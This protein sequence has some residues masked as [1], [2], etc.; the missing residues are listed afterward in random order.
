MIQKFIL[1]S[2]IILLYLAIVRCGVALTPKATVKLPPSTKTEILRLNLLYGDSDDIY[3]L[4]LGI[5]NVVQ[6]HL[7]GIQ[8]GVVNGAERATGIQIGAVNNA[9]ATWSLLK[10][11]LFNLNFFLDSGRRQPRDTPESI[12]RRIKGDAGFS[13]G[14]VN[15]ASGRYNVGLFN[16]G[17]GWNV[18][19]VNWNGEDSGVSMGA[20]NLGEKE[21]FQIG[22]LNFC[23]EGLLPVMILVNYCSSSPNKNSDT[24]QKISDPNAK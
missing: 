13:V 12:E 9:T 6:N 17:Y 2:F 11:G 18:G 7:I 8:I 4:N 3:G 16:Y 14:L 20:V 22:I 19:F 21:N 23:K 10:I 5:A 24:S 1:Y 15:L